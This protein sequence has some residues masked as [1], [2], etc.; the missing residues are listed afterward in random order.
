MHEVFQYLKLSTSQSIAHQPF[1]CVSQVPSVDPAVPLVAVLC[2]ASTTGYGFHLDSA[3]LWSSRAYLPERPHSD[4]VGH[5]SLSYLNPRTL[6][7][8]RHNPAQCLTAHRLGSQLLE[9]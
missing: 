7:V 5:N 9:F 8:L 3:S 6:R 2:Q 1:T 4:H